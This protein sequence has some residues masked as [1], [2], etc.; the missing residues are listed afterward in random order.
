MALGLPSRRG[1]RG[2]ATGALDNDT[3]TTTTNNNNYNNDNN[4]NDNLTPW[5]AGTGGLRGGYDTWYDYLMNY[6]VGISSLVDN[7][8]HMN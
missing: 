4:D 1:A 6:C 5:T 7:I 3:T 8:Y 2:R